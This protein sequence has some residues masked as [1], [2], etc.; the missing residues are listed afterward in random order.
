MNVR[1]CI[2]ESRILIAH[3]NKFPSTDVHFHKQPKDNIKETTR[4]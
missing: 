4:R 2:F 3:T 1:S